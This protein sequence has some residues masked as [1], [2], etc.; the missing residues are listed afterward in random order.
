MKSLNEDLKSGQFHKVYL[1]YGDEAYL[2]KLYKDRLREAIVGEDTMNYAYFE[3]KGISD[4]EV[5]DLA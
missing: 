4:K 1:L 2:K 5:I 3:G